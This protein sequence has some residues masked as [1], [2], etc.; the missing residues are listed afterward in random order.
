MDTRTAIKRPVD[1]KPSSVKSLQQI[2]AAK[3]L[4]QLEKDP[5]GGRA[6]LDLSDE[7]QQVFLPHLWNEYLRARATERE[8]K[9]SQQRIPQQR[10]PVADG[11]SDIYQQ[12]HSVADGFLFSVDIQKKP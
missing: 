6:L 3:L 9:A 2:C 10:P 4:D 11:F 7:E 8:Y 1:P 12:R 5:N